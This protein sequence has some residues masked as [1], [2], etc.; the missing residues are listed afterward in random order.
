MRWT[1]PL[2]A[3]ALFACKTQDDAPTETGLDSEINNVVDNDGDGFGADEDCDD[4][5][6]A[7]NPEATETCDGLDQDCDGEADEGAADAT[8]WPVDEDGDGYASAT[9][10]V[11]ACEAPPDTPELLGDCDD[12][13]DGVYPGAPESCGDGDLNCDGEPSD[14]DSDGDGAID[15]EDCAPDDALVSPSAVETCD[16]VDQ[17]CDGEVDEDATDAA[18]Y[19]TDADGDGFGDG[20]SPVA[21]CGPEDGITEDSTDCDDDDAEVN[22]AT[23]CDY[24]LQL[25]AP[26]T[27]ALTL[28]SAQD[29][30]VSLSGLSPVS[31]SA[32]A[33]EAM[34][35]IAAGD[36]TLRADAPFLASMVT[37][38]SGGDQLV[39]AR[40]LD[41]SYLS[42]ALYTWSGEHVWVVNPSSADIDV[43]LDLWDGAAWVMVNADVVIAEGSLAFSGL[44]DGVYRLTASAPVLAWG[45]AVDN[46]ENHLEQLVGVSGG[47]FDAQVR[48][49][50]PEVQGEAGLTGLCVESAG[51]TYS[52]SADGG[53]GTAGTLAFGEGFSA[54]IAANVLYTVDLTGAVL[55]RNESTPGGYAS[56]D[57]TCMDADLAPGR[58]GGHYDTEFILQAAIGAATTYPTRRTDL[59]AAV[60]LDGTT[61]T[62]E[63][64]DDGAWSPVLT[65][66]GDAGELVS[67]GD[68]YASAAVLRVTSSAPVHVQMTHTSSEFAWSA[69]SDHYAD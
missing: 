32:G 49:T 54:D 29:T 23:A 34:M 6:P 62:V 4:D 66:S 14:L 61:I 33:P 30:T 69:F 15:C 51:C 65:A 5:D 40:G 56:G 24:V 12:A 18:T 11:L 53:A 41:G 63:S 52:V 43:T 60:Y 26:G 28:I 2:W 36:Y 31:L 8:A 27:T 46:I 37:T 67:L 7:V 3:L 42:D 47:F 22:P 59:T 45:A 19:Y 21:A 35:V 17:D 55:M 48:W 57:G 50:L 9:G 64:Y 58:S 13:D 44:A 1:A 16:G 38:A 10:A 20:D 68:D 39:S 25:R